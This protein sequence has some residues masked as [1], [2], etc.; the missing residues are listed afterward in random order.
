MLVLTI[1]GSAALM[2]ASIG[3]YGLM[4]YS[5]AQRTQEIWNTAS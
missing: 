5:V 2:L 4:A 1:F 3:I